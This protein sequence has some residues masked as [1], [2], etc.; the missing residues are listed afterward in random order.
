MESRAEAE[1]QKP[2]NPGW[3]FFIFRGEPFG[4][5]DPFDKLR[6]G[7][8]TAGRLRVSAYLINNVYAAPAANTSINK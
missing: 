6:A 5:F 2:P 7:K 1:P 4:R 3:S 8:L